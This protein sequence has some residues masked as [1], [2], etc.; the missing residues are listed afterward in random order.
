MRL[1]LSVL[2][3][4][5]FSFSAIAGQSACVQVEC[6]AEYV[7]EF[8]EVEKEK[9]SESIQPEIKTSLFIVTNSYDSHP[10]VGYDQVCL[11]I[12]TPPPEQALV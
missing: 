11:E 5:C 4:F 12:I 8:E 3:L 10:Q 1:F 6:P 7:V 9:N 2:L